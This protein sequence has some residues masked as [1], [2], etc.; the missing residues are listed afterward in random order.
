MISPLSCGRTHEDCRGSQGVA[1]T[2]TALTGR[3]VRC[4]ESQWHNPHKPPNGGEP[5]MRK[6]SYSEELV[7]IRCHP[8]VD[9]VV[10]VNGLEHRLQMR[11]DIIKN[12]EAA[13]TTQSKH[14][15]GHTNLRSLPNGTSRS[16]QRQ[17]WRSTTGKRPC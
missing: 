1:V 12:K 9:H 6:G 14:E 5:T 17:F 3:V 4:G 8:D 16:A 7:K 2:W 13:K 15:D 10:G 11:D